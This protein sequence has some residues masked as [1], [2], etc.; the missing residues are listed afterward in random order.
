MTGYGVARRLDRLYASAVVHQLEKHDRLVVISDLHMG[1]GGRLDDFSHNGPLLENALKHYYLPEG[2]HLL[3]NGDIE[4][5]QR[6]S[7]D[8]V[9]ARWRELIH[10]FSEFESLNRLTRLIGNHDMSPAS[11]GPGM[12]EPGHA[13]RLRTASGEILVFH[14]HQAALYGPLFNRILGW[15]LRWI[16]SPLGIRNYT[17]AFNSR[18]KY[19]YEKRI[20]RFARSNRIMTIVGH[21]HRPLFESMSR[22]DT[23]KM[24]IESACRRLA[25]KPDSR[26]AADIRD[27]K[28]EFFELTHSR[29][30]YA[31]QSMLYHQGLL[32]PCLF[33]SGSAIA[34]GGVTALEIDR[35]TANLSLWF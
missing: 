16:A 2:F 26:L 7:M 28:S 27:M 34:P 6:F 12:R 3:L 33:N 10:V 5:L 17:V 23:L 29:K 20:Y 31:G 1:D 13:V 24:Q 15:F 22:L 4:E 18:R 21:T 14:G 9:R 8:R 11:L 19:R 30:K 35:G 25:R 32:V